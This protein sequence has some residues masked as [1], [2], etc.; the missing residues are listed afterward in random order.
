MQPVLWYKERGPPQELV[1]HLTYFG[2]FHVEKNQEPRGIVI[3]VH[4]DDLRKTE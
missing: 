4:W 1:A 2:G 3:E